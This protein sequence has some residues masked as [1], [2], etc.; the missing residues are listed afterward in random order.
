M[1]ILKVL[2]L[3]LSGF[4]TFLIFRKCSDHTERNIEDL[5][6]LIMNGLSVSYFSEESYVNFLHGLNACVKE[7]VLDLQAGMLITIYFQSG[8]SLFSHS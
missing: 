3:G 5:M 4:Y 7:N 6:H 2:C 8:M 1:P